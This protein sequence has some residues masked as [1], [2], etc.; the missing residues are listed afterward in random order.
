M[1]IIKAA[2]WVL[3]GAGGVWALAALP[4]SSDAEPVSKRP[5][6]LRGAA[7][8]QDRFREFRSDRW[9]I[10]DGWYNGSYMVNDWRADQTVV[11]DGV[12]LILAPNRTEHAAYSSGE[13]QSVQT[14]G[15]GYF[16]ARLRAA[17]GSG[18]VTG[19]F[20]YTGPHW[21][22]EWNEIDVE[23]VAA[24]PRQVMFTY[25]TGGEKVSKIVDLGFDAT[26]SEHVY[27]FDWQPDSIRWYV[28]GRLMHEARGDA[29]PL[30][31]EKQKIMFSL[32]GSDTLTEW[33]RPFDPTSL[34]STAK[35]TCVSY[36]RSFQRR[37]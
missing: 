10:S 22:N 19:F 9:S 21:G 25:F 31:R 33:L 20:T 15:H 3:A 8:F 29:L 16:E 30:P 4:S 28:D 18:I 36:S 5:Q 11:A 7:E 37:C 13:V 12:E 23:I 1:L 17:S 35:F 26:K 2:A 24:K 34:P 27:G 32:W 14:Y 6:L